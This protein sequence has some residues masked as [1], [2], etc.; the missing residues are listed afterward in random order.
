MMIVELKMTPLGIYEKLRRQYLKDYKGHFIDMYEGHN[1][2]DRMATA[3]AL[4]NTKEAW[5][6]QYG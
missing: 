2:A 1:H 5:R 3:Y 4:R 6:R